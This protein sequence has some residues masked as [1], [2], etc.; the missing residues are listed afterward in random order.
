MQFFILINC[1]QFPPYFTPNFINLNYSYRYLGIDDESVQCRKFLSSKLSMIFEDFPHDCLF[2]NELISDV[3][4]ER[5][6]GFDHGDPTLIITQ[7]INLLPIASSSY[8]FQNNIEPVF[9]SNESKLSYDSI[10]SSLQSPFDS[11]DEIHMKIFEHFI[12]LIVGEV[13]FS[14]LE[15]TSNQLSRTIVDILEEIFLYYATKVL[16][17]DFTSLIPFIQELFYKAQNIWSRNF[18]MLSRNYF[19]E[20]QKM[21]QTAITEDLNNSEEDSMTPKLKIRFYKYLCITPTRKLVSSHVLFLLNNFNHAL[22]SKRLNSS[23]KSTILESLK[24]L[25]SYLSFNNISITSSSSS[26]EEEKAEN[27]KDP[28][29]DTSTRLL[30]PSVNNLYQN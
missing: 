30:W 2:Y 16:S 28:D 6:E 23:T 8:C 26:I 14:V 21:L 20:C 1:L 3:I 12:T 29:P 15:K 25:L 19:E 4:N 10:I 27:K 22:S 9:K 17:Y 5:S 18:G 24:S 11:N 13:L 7:V